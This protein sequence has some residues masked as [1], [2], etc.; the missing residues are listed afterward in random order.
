[1]P[2]EKSPDREPVRALKKILSDSKG[3]QFP[4]EHKHEKVSFCFPGI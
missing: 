1:M 4:S 3:I 2:N